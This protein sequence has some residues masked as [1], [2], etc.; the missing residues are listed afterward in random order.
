MSS[1]GHILATGIPP[2]SLVI[3]VL[4][5]ARQ[6]PELLES[7]SRQTLRPDEVIVVDGGSTDGTLELLS[8][9]TDH[10]LVQVL[11]VP[12]A[13]ISTGRNAGIATAR[14]RLIAVTDAGVR[15][16]SSWLEKLIAPL[17]QDLT[18]VDVVGGFFVPDPRSTFEVAL[19]A[20]TLP[21]VGEIDPERFLPSSRSFAFRKS[22]FVS[23]VRYPEWL[24]FCEDLV[25]DMAAQ[26]FGATFAF[27]PDAI[28][29]FRPR[30]SIQTFWRQYYQY[31]RG[32][33]KAGLFR[34]RHLMRYGTYLVLLP[35]LFLV[36]SWR[37]RAL[38]LLGASIYMQAPI[39]RIW[40]RER[41]TP[42]RFLMLIVLAGFLRAVGDV[43]KMAG[44]PAG[45]RWRSKRYGLN[46]DWRTIE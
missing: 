38:G 36:R 44:Y 26:E 33:G 29:R 45:L 12:G 20:S 21:D 40:K 43:A 25:F 4:N 35:S 30:S 22:L 3:T 31:A 17:C 39:R 13:N 15:L 19:A 46:R 23:G 27:Q 1:N 32:D 8:R 24:D 6:L 11:S 34:R 41:P 10:L 28:V 7:I 16:D 2:V 42:L 37:W 9:W 18:P 14:N 5:E